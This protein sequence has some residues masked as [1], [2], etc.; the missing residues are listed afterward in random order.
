MLL[1]LL[2]TWV[3]SI[4]TYPAG[5]IATVISYIPVYLGVVT[6]TE[7]VLLAAP[8]YIAAGYLQWYVLV[9]N[10]FGVSPN[11]ASDRTTIRRGSAALPTADVAD[12][13]ER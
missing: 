5:V 10:H 12:Q 3:A 6:A 9:P 13:R 7:A 8:L 2:G 11:S 4:L 1:A